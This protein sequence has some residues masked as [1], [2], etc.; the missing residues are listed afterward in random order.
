MPDKLSFLDK[1][2]SALLVIGG[3][4]HALGTVLAFAPFSDVWVWSLGSTLA[5]ILIGALNWLRPS[6]AAD[7]PLVITVMLASFAWVFVVLAFAIS[8]GTLFD[9]RVLWHVICG[10][11]LG[12][13]GLVTLR[14]VK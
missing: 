7:R 8:I 13:F 6:R 1:A 4:L 9:F 2:L 3:L 10:L 11:G 12:Y 5:A 14:S